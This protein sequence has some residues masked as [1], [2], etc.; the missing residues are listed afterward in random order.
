M[1]PLDN[2]NQSEARTAVQDVLLQ[3]GLVQVAGG[4]RFTY[5]G[6][7]GDGPSSTPLVRVGI[8]NLRLVDR[9]HLGGKLADV[10]R[11]HWREHYFGKISKEKLAAWATKMREKNFGRDHK[12]GWIVSDSSNP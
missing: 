4:S 2:C 10:T 5:Y 1:R 3:A 11:Q 6:L 7:P 12:L 8:R 9:L